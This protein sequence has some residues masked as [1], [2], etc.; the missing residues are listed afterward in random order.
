MSQSHRPLDATVTKQLAAIVQAQAPRGQVMTLSEIEAG[1]DALMHQIAVQVTEEVLA[2]Q[3]SEAEKKG[4]R[5][6]AAGTRRAGG[7]T[8]SGLS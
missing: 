5:Q 2:A 4:H 6:T 7:G 3:I 8:E 1:I